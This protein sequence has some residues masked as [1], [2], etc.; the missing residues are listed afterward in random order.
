MSKTCESCGRNHDR[1]GEYCENCIDENE[2]L[3]PFEEVRESLAKHI[4][5]T[6]GYAE[7]AALK[8]A[9]SILAKQKV[10]KDRFED[11]EKVA[12][13]KISKKR[14][15]VKIFS[16]LIIILTVSV[17]LISWIFV[18]LKNSKYRPKL[19]LSNIASTSIKQNEKY[20]IFASHIDLD[21][22][23]DRIYLKKMDKETGV[24]SHIGT[25]RTVMDFDEFENNV[26]VNDDYIAWLDRRH[27]K[28][29]TLMND[30]YFSKLGFDE[31]RATKH[32]LMRSNLKICK[33]WIAYER[34]KLNDAGECSGF[35]VYAI[36]LEDK[37]F[38]E[39]V[40]PEPRLVAE[41]PDEIEWDIYYEHK[42][43]EVCVF[44]N[45]INRAMFFDST[46]KLKI[47]EFYSRKIVLEDVSEFKKYD[48]IRSRNIIDR[49]K[50]ASI[51][52][53]A[54]KIGVVVKPDNE[55]G[56]F[57]DYM[58]FELEYF[59]YKKTNE[60]ISFFQTFDFIID[61]FSSVYPINNYSKNRTAFVFFERNDCDFADVVNAPPN[62]NLCSQKYFMF[63]Y[64]SKSLIELFILES[65]SDID[66]CNEKYVVYRPDVSS[67]KGE[68]S[69]LNLFNVSEGKTETVMKGWDAYNLKEESVQLDGNKLLFSLPSNMKADDMNFVYDLY[70]IDLD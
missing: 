6:Q 1:L 31:T 28:D 53:H 36:N 33:N 45:V 10:W 22:R 15:S 54:I 20:L 35:Q 41:S 13:Q 56:S 32:S 16:T 39:G 5:E 47:D 19:L 61:S 8:V 68:K 14:K 67:K 44:V 52:R 9:D 64:I 69:T 42:L 23:S 62:K 37:E 3:K 70:Q 40:I 55:V 66:I 63:D 2:I 65:K 30:I 58:D 60:D 43:N 48:K 11:S 18:H 17:L 51:Q 46:E 4:S 7:V 57:V 24:I 21:N 12:I 34:E 29:Y 27:T 49:C 25:V 38:A 59:E 50:N 26:V